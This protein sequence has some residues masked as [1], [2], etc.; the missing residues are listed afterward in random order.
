MPSTSSNAAHVLLLAPSDVP[1]LASPEPAADA[2]P[3]APARRAHPRAAYA[4]ALSLALHALI[5][6]LFW[7]WT[8]T[9]VPA[10]ESPLLQVRLSSGV[11]K[12]QPIPA[13]PQRVA[14]PA[15]T[16]R[17]TAAKPPRAP[18]PVAAEPRN[19]ATSVQPAPVTAAAQ[20]LPA[21]P[22]PPLP[23]LPDT[24]GTPLAE[25][26]DPLV[27]TATLRVLDWLAQ[28][29]RYPG[30]A[31]RA[32]L[33]GTVEVMV[34]LMPDGRLI[35]QRIVQSSGHA[36]LDKAALDLLRRASPVPATAFFTGAARR[37]ELRLPIVYR[38][39]I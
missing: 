5:A 12:P 6:L 2:L 11:S 29:R 10:P 17:A 1:V 23:A 25:E 37:L 18:A 19:T 30:P 15:P 28:H 26:T 20:T 31:R 33:Q 22:A 35:D 3:L 14:A 4:L 34:V 38:L 32:R 13:A 7:Q 27:D 36:V 39:S 24:P 16:P 21:E 8:S 9:F